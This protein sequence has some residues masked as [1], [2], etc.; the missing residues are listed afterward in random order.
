MSIHRFSDT[1]HLS[2]LKTYLQDW[3]VLEQHSRFHAASWPLGDGWMDPLALQTPLTS[4][5]QFHT[6]HIPQCA[7]QKTFL[8]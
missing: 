3:S 2:E 1:N 7:G 6:V 4:H 8:K 5:I